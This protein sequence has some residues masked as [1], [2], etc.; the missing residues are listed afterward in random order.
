MTEMTESEVNT[1]NLVIW[2]RE[3]NDFHDMVAFMDHVTLKQIDIRRANRNDH[4]QKD[5]VAGKVYLILHSGNWKLSRA[6]SK[7][8]GGLQFDVGAYTT[9]LGCLDAVF[10]TNLPDIPKELIPR[11]PKPVRKPECECCGRDYE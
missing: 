2:H 3:I 11:I 1:A 6:Y 10:E 7:Y 9:G 8:N 5:I 4:D